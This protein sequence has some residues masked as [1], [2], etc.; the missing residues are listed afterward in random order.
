MIVD[1]LGRPAKIGDTIL[2][3]GYSTTALDC[4]TVIDK[5]T[6]T[7]IKC[8]VGISSSKYDPASNKWIKVISMKNYKIMLRKPDSFIIINEQ[9]AHNKAVWPE[10][11]I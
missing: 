6:K 4:I 3:K 9:L 1:I 5:I 7:G 8:K 11:Y 10:L 2:T